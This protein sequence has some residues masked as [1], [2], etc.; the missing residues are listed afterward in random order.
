MMKVANEIIRELRENYSLR[1]KDI[2]QLLGITQQVYSK[3]E[4]TGNGLSIAQII[5]LAKYY[6]VT[7]DYLLGQVNYPKYLG[8]ADTIIVANRT[9]GEFLSQTLSLEKENRN[10]L[11]RFSDYLLASQDGTFKKKPE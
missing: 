2:A 7:T 6:G 4:T 9:A 5:K 11:I 1:Q 8:S 10:A 3:Y